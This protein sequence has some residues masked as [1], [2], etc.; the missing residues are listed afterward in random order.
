VTVR[1]LADRPGVPAAILTDL[2]QVYLVARS[3]HDRTAALT[4]LD[5][6][7]WDRLVGS[8]TNLDDGPLAAVA[9]GMITIDDILFKAWPAREVLAWLFRPGDPASLTVHRAAARADLVRTALWVRVA[10]HLAACPRTTDQFSSCSH[11]AAAATCVMC[12]GPPGSAGC[13]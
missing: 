13:A 11:C 10:Q 4:V 8:S 6:M 3:G 9:G 2:H 5:R 7:A 1:A 12:P